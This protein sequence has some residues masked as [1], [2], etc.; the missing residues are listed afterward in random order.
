M[1]ANGRG[2]CAVCAPPRGEPAPEAHDVGPLEAPVEQPA[3]QPGEAQHRRAGQGEHRERER[4]RL[5]ASPQGDPEAREQCQ[6]G[7][8]DEGRGPHVDEDRERRQRDVAPE[9][10]RVGTELECHRRIGV[11]QPERRVRLPE[12]GPHLAQVSRVFAQL[13]DEGREPQHCQHRPRHQQRPSQPAELRPVAHD[14]CD[15]RPQEQGD[16]RRRHRGVRLGDERRHPG[17]QG[18]RPRMVGGRVEGEEEQEREREDQDVRLPRIGDAVGTERVHEHAD[19]RQAPEHQDHP[20]PPRRDHGDAHDHER[21]EQER[22][23]LERGEV[24]TEQPVRDREDVEQEGT[25]LVPPEA[26]VRAD[27]RRVARSDV[28]HPQLDEGVVPVD[29]ELA[30]HQHDD[31]RHQERQDGQDD[32]AADHPAPSRR[33]LGAHGRRRLHANGRTTPAP[34]PTAAAPAAPPARSGRRRARSTA[35]RRS[36]TTS[37]GWS[38]A[39]HPRPMRSR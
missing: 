37:R 11:A 25:G 5:V 12:E 19:E 8:R 22:A 39:P 31:E 16:G 28:A 7:E 10:R 27:E 24:G 15:Q 2:E 26:L 30:A 13:L 4:R 21:V 18:Q 20:A 32:G 29:G 34:A 14:H 6:Q 33:A 23:G 3:D 36:R 35:R 17:C 9:P 38:S 1:R